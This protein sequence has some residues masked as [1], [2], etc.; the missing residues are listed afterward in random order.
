MTR[1]VLLFITTFILVALSPLAALAAQDAMVTV[2]QA[3][4]RE[5]PELDAAIIESR[6][7]G[8]KIR[9]SQYNKEGWFK[10]RSSN[11]QY[12]WIWQADITVLSMTSDVKAANLEMI[13][14]NHERRHTRSAPWFFARA[15]GGLLAAM[16][17]NLGKSFRASRTQLYPGFGGFGEIAV[18]VQDKFKLAARLLTY[19]AQSTVD[20]K[21]NDGTILGVDVTHTGTA[22]LF[23]VEATINDSD[24]F[25]L[26]SSLYIGMAQSSTTSGAPIPP[27]VDTKTV[28]G[29]ALAGMLAFGG[30]YWLTRHFAILGDLDF[31]LTHIP[32][33]PPEKGNM[34]VTHAVFFLN[35][36]IQFAF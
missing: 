4:I 19:S 2:E 3:A 27:T 26:T 25:D 13:D 8:T 32:R 6:N 35:A 34:V 20:S 29:S 11:G 16:S 30:K 7:A 12:G 15:G 18:R 17:P 23:G 14:K 33:T 5:R 31:Y 22:G 1:Q 36:G 28:D 10:T 24:T 21:Q 9:V